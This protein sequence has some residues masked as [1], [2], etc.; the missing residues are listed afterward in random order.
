MVRLEDAL[1]VVPEGVLV[2]RRGEEVVVQ[3]GVLVVV[4]GGRED[5]GEFVERR[6]QLLDRVLCARPRAMWPGGVAGAAWRGGGGA[7][8]A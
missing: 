3:P 5:D 8:G 1:V 7:L 4:D 2:L 6:D